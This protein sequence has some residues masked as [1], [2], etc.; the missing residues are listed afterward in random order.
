MRNPE[1]KPATYLAATLASEPG[2]HSAYRA[3]ID[4]E[5]LI[6][7]GIRAQRLALQR[8]NGVERYDAK[9]RRMLASWTDADEERADKSTARIRKDASALLEPYGATDVSVAGDPRGFCLTFRLASGRSN[10][11]GLGTWGV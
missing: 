7:M 5:A 8:C 1:P 9:A 11:V 3:A 6:R 4:A 10:S 2:E